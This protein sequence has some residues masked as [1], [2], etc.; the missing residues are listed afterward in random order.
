MNLFGYN[1][2]YSGGFKLFLKKKSCVQFRY[3][4][5]KFFTLGKRSYSNISFSLYWWDLKKK[6]F[7]IQLFF[8]GLRVHAEP[9]IETDHEVNS[10]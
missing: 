5:A 2:K 3:M 6:R 8:F 1:K 7:I 4:Y 9:L 10:V